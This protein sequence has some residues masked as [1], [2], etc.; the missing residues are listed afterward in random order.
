MPDQ[1]PGPQDQMMQWIT[2]KWISKPI[3]L[4]AELGLA[5][6]MRQGPRTVEDLARQTGTHA[7]S[8]NRLLRALAALGIFAEAG[9]DSYALTPLAE[10]LLSEA[11]RPMALMF[12]SDWHDKAWGSLAHSVATGQPG[13][14]HAFGMPSFDWLERNPRARAILDQGQGAKAWGFA[15]QVLGAYDFS[16]L[17]PLCDLGGGRGV[18]L[19][20]LLRANPDLKGIVADLP[21]AVPAAQEAVKQAGLQA[22]CQVVACDFFHQAPPVCDCYVLANVLHDWDDGPCQAILANLAQAMRPGSRALLVEYL[23][24]PGPGFSVAK[25]L[26]LEMLVMSGGRERTGPQY[27]DLLASAGLSLSSQI[28]LAGGLALLEAVT[29]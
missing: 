17:E 8:L 12:L 24:E 6:L 14:D 11:M 26:D 1:P 25:L 19:I 23:L 3:H 13:F 27:Q 7:P 2:S 22:R 18:F 20:E 15:Q 28:P 16:G 29:A 5:D 4:A 9:P 21:G 10:C